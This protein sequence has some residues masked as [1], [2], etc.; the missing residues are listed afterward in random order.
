MS[1]DERGER[2]APGRLPDLSR[3]KDALHTPFAVRLDDTRIVHLTLEEIRSVD[4]RPGWESFSLIFRGPSP[5]VF[6][7]GTFDIDHAEVGTFPIFVVAV[8]TEGDGQE[9]EACFYRRST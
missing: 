4:V 9:Y 2:E 7:D 8:A 5:P 6:W 3:L 1:F